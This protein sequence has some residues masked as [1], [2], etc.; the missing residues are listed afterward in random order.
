MLSF[1]VLAFAF[2]GVPMGAVL[3][4][5]VLFRPFWQAWTSRT[6]LA[7]VSEGLAGAAAATATF[8]ILLALVP[9]GK[10]LANLVELPPNGLALGVIHLLTFEA[11]EHR[12]VRPPWRHVVTPL[13]AVVLASLIYWAVP[14]LPE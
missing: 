7:F 9:A 1:L 6:V 3:L 12:A 8:V 10:S 4:L 14:S 5:W 11:A 13:C 2:Q